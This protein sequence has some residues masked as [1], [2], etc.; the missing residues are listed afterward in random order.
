V[1]KKNLYPHG[2]AIQ[3][4]WSGAPYNQNER[5]VVLSNVKISVVDL[6]GKRESLDIQEKTTMYKTKMNE[7]DAIVKYLNEY[8]TK[9]NIPRA[10]KICTQRLSER[11]PLEA[12]L[13]T[14]VG[15]D[16]EKWNINPTAHYQH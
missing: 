14:D 16:G 7:I 9:N 5:P 12:L 6:N 4:Y 10:R 15:F 13:S 2:G 11:I 8:V 1:T 3:S